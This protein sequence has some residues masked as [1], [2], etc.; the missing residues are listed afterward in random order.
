MAP[1]L[2]NSIIDLLGPAPA[3]GF[4][5]FQEGQRVL[6]NFGEKIVHIDADG[7]AVLLDPSA[8]PP[9]QAR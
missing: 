6:T 5:D 8:Y 3:S 2:S 7:K 4:V 1:K 9:R